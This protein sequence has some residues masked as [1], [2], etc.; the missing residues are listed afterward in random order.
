MLRCCFDRYQASA[1]VGWPDEDV[2]FN[3]RGA[4]ACTPPH[5]HVLR[6]MKAVDA[7]Q[8]LDT[9]EEILSED[10]LLAY[11]LM[12]FAN[13]AALGARQPIDSLRRALVL[14]GYSPLEKWL[15][16]LLLHA[17][18]EPD[19][20][21]VRQAM[22]QRAQLTIAAAGC[23]G[24]PRAAQR[25]VFVRPVLPAGRHPGRTPGRQPGPPAPV[26]THP[27]MPRCAKRGR[28]PPAWKWPLPWKT[29][30]VPKPCAT[31][32]SSTACTW[33]P[34]TAPCCA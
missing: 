34:S 7:D 2:L 17:C 21:P 26:R 13:S 29:K 8:P 24:Q 23:R 6:L 30:P 3:L 32:A 14:L 1:V 11:R 28:T 27:P 19:L 33:R 31:C 9:F 25:S 20:Q 15:G 22:V 5:T 16:N 18:E 10:P 4:K 12:L